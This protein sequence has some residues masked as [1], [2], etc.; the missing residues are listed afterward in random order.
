MF[1]S[2][3]TKAGATNAPL[4]PAAARSA[5]MTASTEGCG[6]PTTRRTATGKAEMGSTEESTSASRGSRVRSSSPPPLQP[7]R[8]RV[9]PPPL[10]DAARGPSS[11][12]APFAA[13]AESE[14]SPG[15]VDGDGLA[16]RFRFRHL[17][18]ESGSRR[19]MGA[20][21]R[22]LGRC[23]NCE[24]EMGVWLG[25]YLSWR[26]PCVASS[27]A[28]R[29]SGGRGGGRARS[30]SA[31]EG[32]TAIGPEAR[33]RGEVRSRSLQT[34]GLNFSTGSVVVLGVGLSRDV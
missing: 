29:G 33:A 8:A 25:A 32:T 15:C 1:S 31:S 34:S 23:E 6:R 17:D 20:E 10:D 27:P 26:R 11:S 24:A 13:P 16:A 18:R 7:A 28:A 21:D 9:P 22:V 2:V 5:A 4:A 19:E 3:G 30:A 14:L 12:P